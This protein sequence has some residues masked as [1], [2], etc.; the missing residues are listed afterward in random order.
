VRTTSTSAR[1]ARS[2]TATPF[3]PRASRSASAESAW[4]TATF[5]R[6]PSSSRSAIEHM[7]A[8]RSTASCATRS[9]VVSY[10]SEDERISP[11]RARKASRSLAA[12]TSLPRAASL[13]GSSLACKGAVPAVPVE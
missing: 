12:G 1:I 2:S 13:M 5:R 7:S 6:R 4:A 3:G 10:S 11:A 9:S 8:S